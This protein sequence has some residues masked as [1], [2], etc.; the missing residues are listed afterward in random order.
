M[1]DFEAILKTFRFD[2]WWFLGLLLLIPLWSWLR[3]RFSPVAAVEFSSGE[4]LRAAS[5]K[6]RFHRR[7]WLLALRYLALALLIAAL[8]RP[9]VEKGLS[10]L[11]ARGINIMLVLD[12][13]STMKK[14]DFTMDNKRVSR[15]QAL[16]KVITE[17]MRSRPHDRIGLVRFDADAFLISPLTLD[18]D[19]L[20]ARLK[21]EKS[22]QGTAPGSGMLIAAEHLL[23]ATNQTKVIIIVSDAEQ[24]NRGPSPGEVAKALVPLGIRAHLIQI[25]DFKDMAGSMRGNEMAEIPKLTG[26]QLFQVAD[27]GGLRSVY[28]QIDLLEKANFKE[29]KQRNYRELMMG[30]AGPALGL[31]LLELLLRQTL[32]RRL[33]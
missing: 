15:A 16:V 20:I 21:E 24:V 6:P 26:G 19:W 33:P 4:L 2:S 1:T 17:F 7:Q 18:H 27:F 32:W 29:D 13:S 3:G 12:W 10:D 9:Q 28:R 30:F 22:G 5:Q 11:D 31:L 23:P 25:V 14:R 8:A